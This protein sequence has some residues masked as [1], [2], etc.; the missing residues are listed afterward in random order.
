[1]KAGKEAE[2]E[3]VKRAVADA[4]KDAVEADTELRVVEQERQGLLMAL[5]NFLDSC[6]PDGEDEDANEVLYEWWPEQQASLGSAGRGGRHAVKES[7]WHD[8]L[9]GNLAGGHASG[10]KPVYG[11]AMLS[12]EAASISGARFSV[13]QGDL[14]RLERA[15]LNF[16]VD[17]H[18][19][20]VTHA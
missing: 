14:A 9:A 3:N 20:Q 11:A 19:D 5:P 12:E 4:A 6:V 8:E 7:K 1:M 18:V 13:L 15:L 10:S 2:V 17:L 16:F